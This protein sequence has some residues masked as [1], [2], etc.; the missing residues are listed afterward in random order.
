ML[1]FSGLRITQLRVD[2]SAPNVDSLGPDI[3]ILRVS[4]EVSDEDGESEIQARTPTHACPFLP[5][6][7]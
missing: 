5:G 6:R 7:R 3:L 2:V 4:D 1:F